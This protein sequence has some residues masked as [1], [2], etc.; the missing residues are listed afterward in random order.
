MDA[1]LDSPANERETIMLRALA[2]LS[3]L[4]FLWAGAAAAAGP[5]FDVH[6]QLRAGETSLL[7]YEAEVEA[8]GIELSG[9]GAMWFGGPHQAR[10]GEPDAIRA[11]HEGV[12][13]LAG[14]P[15]DVAP[16]AHCH[17]YAGPATG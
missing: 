6:V 3:F 9:L 15:T 13:S 11:G 2:I 12:I 16:I 14:R 17:P 4:S 7:A 10:Q 5:V 8:V 1:L